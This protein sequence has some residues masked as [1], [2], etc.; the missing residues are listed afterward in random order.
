[1]HH[2]RGV[3]GEQPSGTTVESGP[4]PPALESRCYDAIIIGSGF[5]GSMVADALVRAGL[6]VLMLERGDWVPRGPRNW[7]EDGTLDL[8][9]FATSETPYRAISGGNGKFVGPYG[10]VG[11]P[12]VFYG[13]VSMRFREADFEAN[14]HLGDPGAGWPYRYAD[15]EPY[16]ARAEQ[17][18]DVAGEAG[19]D[20]T[21]PCRSGPYPQPPPA[22][23]DTSRMVEGA[24]RELGFHPFPLPLAINYG[25]RGDRSSC[26]GCT[27]CD[28]FACAIGA[29]NDLATCVLPDLMQRGLHLEHNTVVTRLVHDNGRVQE[30]ETCEKSTGRRRRFRAS[31]F[32]LAAGALGS[33]H[34]LLASELER[35]NPAGHLV[36][37][38]LMRHCSAI[39]FGVFARQPNP[40]RQFHKQLGIHD[41]YFG[42]PSVTSPPGKLGSI[43]QL[44]TPPVGLIRAKLPGPIGKR[45]RPAVDHLTG[46]LAMAE[47]A[48]RVGNGVGVDWST[49]DRFGIPQLT[50][51]HR[52][53]ARDRAARRALVERSKRILRRAGALFCLVHEIKTFS[54]ALGTARFGADPATSV[55]DPLCRFRGVANLYVVDAAFMPTSAAV[56]PSLTISANALR[57]G[58]AI[59]RQGPEGSSWT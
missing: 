17:M 5:G 57:V 58:E 51:E 39:V 33:P 55:L 48:P 23:S 40:R 52:Y 49:R 6:D 14:G 53:T 29:K 15:L 28:T 44:Q 1:M 37:R 7:D 12:S 50:I 10:C 38:H 20:P 56:N 22:L 45:I 8:T 9:R 59:A 46:L 16:Y 19:A 11:G 25:S 21:E 32:V 2:R 18:L 27:T 54:H 13:G 3:Q 47:D 24:A 4:V 31:T 43:Q 36:G 35:L 34:V 30:V 42:H 26:V 41:L